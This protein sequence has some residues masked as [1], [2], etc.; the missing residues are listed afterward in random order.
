LVFL[1]HVCLQFVRRL[2][3][4]YPLPGY[5]MLSAFFMRLILVV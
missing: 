4:G 2:L 5:F 1:G 3:L